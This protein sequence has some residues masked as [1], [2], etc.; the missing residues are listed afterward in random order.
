M[1]TLLNH[2]TGQPEDVPDEQVTRAVA[3]GGFGLPQGAIAV[4]D[5]KGQAFE[6]DADEA[7]KAFSAGDFR[8]ETAGE[9]LARESSDSPVTAFAAGAARGASFGLSDLALTELGGVSPKKL[10]AVK[11]G[12]VG[13]SVTGEVAGAVLPALLPG[14]QATVAGAAGKLGLAAEKLAGSAL[15]KGVAG[16]IGAKAVGGATEGFLFGMGN[17]VSESA[18]DDTEL[19]AEKLISGGGVG[20]LLGG[21]GAGAIEGVGA[22]LKAVT[23]KVLGRGA[24]AAEG[25]ASEAAE[26]ATAGAVGEGAPTVETRRGLADVLREATADPVIA[27]GK[28]KSA[29][30]GAA[31][32]HVGTLKKVFEA[33]DLDFPSPEGF[34]LRD[35][36]LKSRELKKLGRKDLA[37]EAP[38]MLL[39]DA[40][41]AEAKT[42]QDKTS[43][44]RTKQEEA[45]RS[46]SEASKR[47]DEVAKYEDLVDASALAERVRTELIDPLKNGTT[48]DKPIARRLEAE[49]KQ[50]AKRGRITFEEAENLKRAYDGHLRWDSETK[51][52]AQEKFRQLRG[53]LNGEIEASGKEM[54]SRVGEDTFATWKAAKKA[55]GAMAELGN[56]AESRLA[57]HQG[58]RVFSLTDNLAG[59]G[60]LV[61]GGL[62]PVGLAASAA[63]ALVNKWGRERLPHILALATDKLKDGGG[64]AAVRKLMEETPI[65]S[66]VAN[67]FK[68]SVDAAVAKSPES[69]G[70]YAGILANA[71]ARGAAD[72]FSTHATLASEDGEYGE[73][74]ARNGFPL[75]TGLDAEGALTRASG[76]SRVQQTIAAHDKRMDEVVDG[77]LRGHR[78]GAGTPARDARESK[79]SFEK[80]AAE[81]AQLATSPQALA[82]R[83]ALSPQMQAAAPGVSAA[84]AATAARAVS[85]LHEVAPKSPHAPNMKALAVPWQPSDA[86]LSAWEKRVRA[87]ERPATVL[88][89]L[90]R[91]TAT[92]EAVEALKAVYPKLHED[93]RQR[94]LERM[95]NL[96][97]RLPFQQRRALTAVF[98]PEFDGPSPAAAAVLQQAHR[99]AMQK[100]MAKGRAS[101]ASGSGAGNS[102]ATQSQRLEGR[103]GV[104]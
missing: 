85:F 5:A 45:G 57:A 99:A 36:D 93:L 15:G 91:G 21:L 89:D 29:M 12:N 46:L 100:E 43:L 49:A 33:L 8:Y 103:G 53:M 2:Q 79:A 11:E 73:M 17:A 97:T 22:G 16:R 34:V 83:F 64:A 30:E 87:V 56:A 24:K 80:R 4:R 66:T 13:A 35:L 54:F 94:V 40:R 84:L 60:G 70:S 55:Y 6:L 1:A 101:Q 90:Q 38:R 19:T 72:L 37:E 92:K 96:E 67:A 9:K 61:A 63:G 28:G 14:G 104:S 41:Y 44:I 47:F 3:S 23:G 82:E 69:F 76:L 62:N 78:A 77:F 98:G 32:E 58:N 59:L 75:E 10:S 68:K 88:E 39:D 51:G 86:E 71:A 27:A 95:A 65:L 74:M 102:L 42:L 18:L 81:L 26:V 7:V 50:L 31:K 52:V 20:A 25:V 48:L